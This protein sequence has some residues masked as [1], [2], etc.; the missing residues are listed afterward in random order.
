MAG[1]LSS[2]LFTVST[3]TQNVKFH[4][5]VTNEHGKDTSGLLE[6]KLAKETEADQVIRRFSECMQLKQ[7]SPGDIKLFEEPEQMEELKLT[8]PFL[9]NTIER[10][11]S[12]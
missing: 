4:C 6:L 8:L 5:E 9:R 2:L 7:R 10:D 11:K 1:I 3:S 12:Q